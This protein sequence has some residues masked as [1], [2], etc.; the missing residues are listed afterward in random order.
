MTS[1]HNHEFINRRFLGQTWWEKM[2][3]TQILVDLPGNGVENHKVPPLG[4]LSEVG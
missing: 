3:F 1:E 2:F 4:R